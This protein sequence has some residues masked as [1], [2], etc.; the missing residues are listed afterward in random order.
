METGGAK[1]IDGK[2][3]AADVTNSIKTQVAAA[4]VKH[5]VI[6][7]LIILLTFL[8]PQEKVGSVP[9]ELPSSSRF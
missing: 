8:L 5:T 1:L 4:K 9:S 2:A 7:L 3:I 6:I